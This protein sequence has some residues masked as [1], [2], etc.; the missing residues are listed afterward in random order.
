MTSFLAWEHRSPSRE[1]FVTFFILN[2]L[3]AQVSMALCQAK[4]DILKETDRIPILEDVY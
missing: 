1:P 4:R 3:E 2:T